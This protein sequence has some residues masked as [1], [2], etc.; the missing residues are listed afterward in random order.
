MLAA[1]DLQTERK[2]VAPL[3]ELKL[4]P[5]FGLG[6]Q[7]PFPRLAPSPP[8]SELGQSDSPEQ[9]SVG[10]FGCERREDFGEPAEAPLRMPVNKRGLARF[11]LRANDADEMPGDRAAVV[12]AGVQEEP[13]A[14]R[15][16]RDLENRRVA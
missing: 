4:E 14:D 9:R 12:D 5:P 8:L 11:D 10:D 16:N 6:H 13:F 7:G 1:N 15:M 2:L 3:V